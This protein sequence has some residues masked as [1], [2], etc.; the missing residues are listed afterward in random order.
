[1]EMIGIYRT[2]IPQIAPIPGAEQVLRTLKS[3]NAR[4]GLITDGREC[5]QQSKLEALRLTIFFERVIIN[6]ARDH[7]KPDDRSF[8]QMERDL[9]A[10]GPRCWYV[11]DNP[12]KDFIG[13]RQLG[14][15]SI[16]LRLPGQLWEAI[17]S[18]DPQPNFT[19]RDLNDVMKTIEGA[20][21]LN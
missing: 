15:R 18:T 21:A 10:A 14:W 16:R 17:E 4:C 7:F 19:V 13:P 11:A 1:D 6:D 5:Q 9:E 2:H 12:S 8:R 20:C 3:G